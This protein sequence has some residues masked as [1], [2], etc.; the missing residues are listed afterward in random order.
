MTACPKCGYVRKLSDTAPEWQCPS[1]GVAY[2]KVQG[3][4]SLVA[5]GAPA[6]VRLIVAS[7]AGSGVALVVA[8]LVPLGLV[9]AGHAEVGGLVLLYWAENVVIGFY[10]VLR[11]LTAGRGSVAEKLGNTLFFC[12]H[13]GMFCLVHGIFVTTLFLS[14]EE[15]EAM[16]AAPQWSGPL[17]VVQQLWLGVNA[18]G[19][20]SPGAL[21]LPLVALA[22]SQGVSFHA[23][24]LRSGRYRTASPNDSFWLPYPRAILLHMCILGAGYL[25]ASYGSTTALLTALVIGKT[26]IDLGLQQITNRVG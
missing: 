24:Y 1:C 2:A 9:L 3:A 13:Y 4:S 21:L 7:E 18:T 26:V 16:S 12:V 20:F 6:E 25:I 10:T 14:S 19:L 17:V 23:I 11:M 22:V 8:N 15:L 5:E